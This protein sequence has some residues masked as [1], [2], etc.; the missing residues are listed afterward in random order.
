MITVRSGARNQKTTITPERDKMA[1]SVS[2][3]RRYY[4]A[5]GGGIDVLACAHVRVRVCARA[6]GGGG[7]G[8][9]VRVR[10]PGDTPPP[11][12]RRSSASWPGVGS[13][14]RG[15]CP[16]LTRPGSPLTSDH[17]PL[18][19]AAPELTRGAT[20]Q[21]NYGQTREDEGEQLRKSPFQRPSSAA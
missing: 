9:C 7:A 3:S 16:A 14:L 2:I 1:C 12:F 10:A 15:R 11:P 4:L 13:E 20:N 18:S 8:P 5:S 17:T 6:G 21:L 19:T